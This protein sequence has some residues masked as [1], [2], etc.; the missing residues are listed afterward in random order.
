MYFLSERNRGAL[1][2]R[3]RTL[4]SLDV[5]RDKMAALS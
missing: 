5:E 3:K 4:R 1:E 2:Q